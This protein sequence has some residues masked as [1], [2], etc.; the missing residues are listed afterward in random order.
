[1]LEITKVL[2]PIARPASAQ[3]KAIDTLVWLFYHPNLRTR[4]STDGAIA[5][6]KQCLLG[7]FQQRGLLTTRSIGAPDELA[8]SGLS[9]SV[10]LSKGGLDDG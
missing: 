1:M 2:D 5:G 7:F 9:G 8:S 6:L 4:A 10:P 3:K